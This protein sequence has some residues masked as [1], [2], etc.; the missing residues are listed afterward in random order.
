MTRSA[1]RSRGALKYIVIA[2]ASAKFAG[3][4]ATAVNEL[5]K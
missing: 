2:T 1:N 5:P 3:H 4:S